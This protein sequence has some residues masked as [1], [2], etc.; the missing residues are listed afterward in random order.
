MQLQLLR[1]LSYVQQVHVFCYLQSVT[2]ET[3]ASFQG[4]ALKLDYLCVLLEEITTFM[5]AQATS[6]SWSGAHEWV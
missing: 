2:G 1:N 6:T 3:R 5:P 4:F